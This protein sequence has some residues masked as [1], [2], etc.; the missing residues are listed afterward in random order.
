MGLA[1]KAHGAGVA[2]ACLAGWVELRETH[3]GARKKRSEHRARELRNPVQPDK[4]VH[5][6]RRARA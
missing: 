1:R 3:H 2:E 5:E 6:A 4:S